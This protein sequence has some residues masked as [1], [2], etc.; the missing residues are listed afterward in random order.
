MGIE[1]VRRD[2]RYGVVLS[3]DVELLDFV[4]RD[5]RAVFMPVIKINGKTHQALDLV[6][7]TTGDE[8][9][10]TDVLLLTMGEPKEE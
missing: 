10:L 8:V 4:V 1:V 3:V 9:L 5:G 7:V 2:G 6:E